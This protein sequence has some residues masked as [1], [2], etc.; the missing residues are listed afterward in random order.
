MMLLQLQAND[1]KSALS[2]LLLGGESSAENPDAF[3]EMLARVTA[4]LKEG[5]NGKSAG[6]PLVLLQDA[7]EE[8]TLPISE[9][10]LE[11]GSKNPKIAELLQLLKTADSATETETTIDAE[12]ATDIELLDPL[13]TRGM[14]EKELRE[15]IR[16]AKGY[17]KSQISSLSQPE[18]MP[19][20]LR[21]LV[22]LAEKIGIDV[23]KITLEEVRQ[24][25]TENVLTPKSDTAPKTTAETATAERKT[26]APQERTASE[27]KPSA[28]TT[29][30]LVRS[31]QNDTTERKS[32]TARTTAKEEGE[33]PL[34]R[35]LREEPAAKPAAASAQA[36][37]V[38]PDTEEVTAKTAVPAKERREAQPNRPETTA[39]AS[40]QAA[41]EPLRTA[42]PARQESRT[43]AETA[44]TTAKTAVPTAAQ[45]ESKT[46]GGALGQQGHASAAATT[47]TAETDAAIAQAKQPLFGEALNRLLRGDSAPAE[48]AATG[49]GDTQTADLPVTESKTATVATTAAAKEEMQLKIAE[50]KETV[51]HFASDIKEAVQNY[52]PPF[53]RIKIQLNPVKLGEVD[54][55]MIQRGNN[56]HIN[57]S[58]NTAAVTTLAQN[59]SELRTQ[60][61]QN[62]MGNATMN[63]SSNANA[64]QQQQQQRQHMAELYEAYENS[65]NFEVFEQLELTIP[66]Y[67]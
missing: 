29:E 33:T 46:G 60:L 12:T 45:G 61:S 37:E 51:R 47:A 34:K 30:E 41:S 26:A 42:A 6:M 3:A 54:V 23:S 58:S 16:D 44:A 9:M 63:F 52:K 62:G 67:V 28:L 39:R 4:Q 56:L 21:G 65:D 36:E 50:A 11:K 57:I 49:D 7:S 59:A 53:T 17:L 14:T 48:A 20:T 66:Q 8:A 40:E 35:L 22:K 10:L 55:T 15:L 24:K 19:N 1:A 13:L 2:Q 18:E 27:S 64:E 5:G 25:A 43:A 31:K 38:R 32:P